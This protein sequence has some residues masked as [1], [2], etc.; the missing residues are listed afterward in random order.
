MDVL[1]TSGG[2]SMGDRD[3]LGALLLKRGALLFDRVLMKPGKPLTFAT[4]PRPNGG[5]LLV[6]GLPGNPG[7][8]YLYMNL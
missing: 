2:V 1:I 4:V 6:F 5:S 8:I 3:L 7:A